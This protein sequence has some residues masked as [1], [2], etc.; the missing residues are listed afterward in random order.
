MSQTGPAAS[1]SQL[2]SS[3]HCHT[4]SSRV[5]SNGE[6]SDHFYLRPYYRI[7][8]YLTGLFTGYLLWKT[9]CRV[10]MKWVCHVVS[11]AILLHST[12]PVIYIF[13]WVAL[14]GWTIAVVVGIS[15][16]YGL[17]GY[18]GDLSYLPRSV[19]AFYQSVNRWSWSLA[20]AWCAFACVTGNGG[21]FKFILTAVQTF[22]KNTY[23]YMNLISIRCDS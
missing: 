5:P 8:P 21:I 12:I 18:F 19:L 1:L 3:T 16:V 22:A 13:Q 17:I 9:D 15:V 20:V 14:L 2:S 6:V 23:I 4:L 11:K 7:A 10:N